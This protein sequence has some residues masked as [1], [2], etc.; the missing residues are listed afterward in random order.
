MRLAYESPAGVKKMPDNEGEK[1]WLDYWYFR[2]SDEGTIYNSSSA[3]QNTEPNAQFQRRSN[4][5]NHDYDDDYHNQSFA[6]AAFPLHSS[7]NGLFSLD[8]LGKRFNGLTDLKHSVLEKRE[9]QCPAGS[10]PCTSIHRSQSCCRK[11]DTCQLVEDT[12]L[13]DVGCCA[14]G[15]SCVGGTTRCESGYTSC[16]NNPGGGCCIPGYKCVDEGCMSIYLPVIL[17]NKDYAETLL[18]N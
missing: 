16:P 17:L 3:A 9:F 8:L 11:G 4:I 13:G 12:G 15:K 1:F 18:N 6:R 5:I 2:E 14:K 10:D 7:E